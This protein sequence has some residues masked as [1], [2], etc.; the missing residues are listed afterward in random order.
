MITASHLADGDKDEDA[1]AN[2]ENSRKQCIQCKALQVG[3][4]AHELHSPRASSGRQDD[5]EDD[6]ELKY[7]TRIYLRHLHRN[8]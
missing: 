7:M 2:A 1:T 5:A 3:N 4:L 6:L 8:S